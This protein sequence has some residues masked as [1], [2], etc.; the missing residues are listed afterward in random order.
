[1]ELNWFSPGV[2]AR[3]LNLH[4][5]LAIFESSCLCEAAYA[6]LHVKFTIYLSIYYFSKC[7]IKTAA[8]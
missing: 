5:I 1:M 4:C 6:Y 2:L 7:P 8:S 3:S